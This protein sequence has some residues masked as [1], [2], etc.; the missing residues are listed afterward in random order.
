VSGDGGRACLLVVAP[1]RWSVSLALSI[2]AVVLAVVSAGAALGLWRSARRANKIAAVAVSI[3][4][5]R[6]HEERKPEFEI[7]ITASPN[8]L[9]HADMKLRLVRP[10]R[11][12]EVVIKILDESYVDHWGRGRPD[13]VTE[14]EAQRFVW[15]PWQFNTGA[16]EQVADTRTTRPRRYTQADGKD[17]EVFDLVKTKPGWWMSGLSPADWERARHGPVKLLLECRINGEKSWEVPYRV[18]VQAPPSWVFD[19]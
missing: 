10:D 1:I 6:R 17:S 7:E 15:G 8:S 4:A 14:L 2:I 5:G 11:L 9:E 16:S 12:D 19:D 3:E 13:G 18:T